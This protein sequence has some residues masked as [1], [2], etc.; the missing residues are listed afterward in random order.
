[1]WGTYSTILGKL[2]IENG[3]E[4]ELSMIITGYSTKRNDIKWDPQY[5]IN[6]CTIMMVVLLVASV[7]RERFPLVIQH[8]GPSFLT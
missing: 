7:P 5:Y 2:S 4:Y 6:A 3:L 8:L 1:M